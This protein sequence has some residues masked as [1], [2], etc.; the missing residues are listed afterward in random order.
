[1]ATNIERA[2]YPDTQGMGEGADA[3]VAQAA[4][5]EVEIEHLA[6][7]GVTIQF[8]EDPTDTGDIPFDANLAE[9]MDAGE[10]L[11]LASDLI[12]S[13]GDDEMGRADW[14]RTY[15]KGLELLGLKIEERTTPWAGACSVAS[16][17]ITEAVVRFQSETVTETFPARGPVRTRILGRE[18]PAKKEAAARIE[19]DMN[20]QLTERMTEF[21][22]EHERL[23]WSLPAAGSAFKKVY[24]DPNLGRPTSIFVPA[25]DVLLPY[26]VS[27]INTA[28]PR[29]T[30]RMR[31]TKNDFKKYVANSFYRD[32]SL[33]DPTR[34]S[35]D[36]QDAK[37]RQTG[38]SS[39][40]DDRYTFYEVVTEIDLPGFEDMNAACEC[41]GI[42][43]PYI[44][45]ID[46]DS[47][48][49]LAIRRNWKEGDK[50]F[51]ARQHFVHYQY[52]PGF[53]AYGFGLFHLI[54]GYARPTHQARGCPHRAGRVP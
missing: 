9:Y 44:I 50:L 34:T 21:R 4:D 15:K 12:T 18:T 52:I 42:A 53:G 7:G 20:Y 24:D 35:T 29:L 6:D 13:I 16:P 3:P 5:V 31:C 48:E 28:C 46:K 30:H 47:S 40:N 38:F 32:V 37:D 8:G 25:E 39:I 14:E 45:T 36:I 17:L 41:T 2:L 19:E 22:P 23:L 54:G 33:P 27:D 11:T 51:R 26:G 10:L 49:V 43:R 1:M